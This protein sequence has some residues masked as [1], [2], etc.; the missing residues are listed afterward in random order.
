[1]APPFNPSQT[2]HP[3]HPTTTSATTTTHTHSHTHTHTHT[4][5]HGIKGLSIDVERLDPQGDSAKLKEVFFGVAANSGNDTATGPVGPAAAVVPWCVYCCVV[6]C[7]GVCLGGTGVGGGRVRFSGMDK[8]LFAKRTDNNDATHPPTHTYTHPL[9][10]S[11]LLHNRCVLCHP[12]PAKPLHRPFQRA[13]RTLGPTGDIKF[14][15]VDCTAKLPSGA[16]LRDW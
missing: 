8:A 1:M 7:V 6:L 15:T 11:L 3:P 14:A 4:H 5:T 10:S 2:M 16:C 13:A 9:H 12:N